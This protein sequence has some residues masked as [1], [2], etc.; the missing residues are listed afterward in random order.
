MS[1]RAS[2]VQ[3]GVQR[4]KIVKSV[5]EWILGAIVVD[6]GVRLSDTIV[7]AAEGELSSLFRLKETGTVPGFTGKHVV[8][9]EVVFDHDGEEFVVRLGRAVKI[10]HDGLSCAESSR[11]LIR[12]VGKLMQEAG[13]KVRVDDKDLD[14]SLLDQLIDRA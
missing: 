3:R 7:S 6:A 10:Y 12:T 5:A 13:V 8:D 2:I 4:R 1:G 11:E 14:L 9:I